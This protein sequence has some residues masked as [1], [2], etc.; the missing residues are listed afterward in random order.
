MM[1]FREGSHVDQ[2]VVRG[3]GAGFAS[4]LKAARHMAVEVAVTH[5]CH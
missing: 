1:I 2:R 4:L 5:L 3:A